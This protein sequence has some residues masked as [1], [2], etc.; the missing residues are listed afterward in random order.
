MRAIYTPP[1]IIHIASVEKKGRAANINTSDRTTLAP[2]LANRI[3]SVNNQNTLLTRP[4]GII[5][6]A[7]QR[8]TAAAVIDTTSRKKIADAPQAPRSNLSSFLNKFEKINAQF[9]ENGKKPVVGKARDLT[10]C[11]ILPPSH[12]LNKAIE[13]P[14]AGS[15][16]LKNC[17][18]LL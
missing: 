1:T 7:A 15:K 12:A 18:I 4:S 2:A 16:R 17:M 3:S 10:G 14:L 9:I 6:A 5:S 8:H 13:K 11:K